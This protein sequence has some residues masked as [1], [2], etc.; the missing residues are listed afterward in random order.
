MLKINKLE[1]FPQVNMFEQANIEFAEV[2]GF[3]LQSS[4]ENQSVEKSEG[5]DQANIRKTNNIQTN[6]MFKGP[7]LTATGKRS[8]LNYENLK[9]Q[10]QVVIEK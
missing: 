4:K 9:E 10:L 7:R 2:A 3:D 8:G 6:K 1:S 5:L